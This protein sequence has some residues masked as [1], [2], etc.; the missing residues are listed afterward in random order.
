MRAFCLP[1]LLIKCSSVKILAIETSCDET[2]A[3][4]IENGRKILS[5]VVA[6][7][8]EI[9]KKYGGIVPEVASRKH[10]ESIA[11]VV[12]QALDDAKTSLKKIDAVAA[13]Y[14]PG[15][16]G[17]LIVGLN[18]AK[19]IAY[20]A[21]KPFIPV[22][23]IEGHI[24]ANFIKEMGD[25]RSEIRKNKSHLR[26][27]ISSLSFPFICLVVS[28]GHTQLVLVKSHGK[29]QTLG[30]TRDDAAGEAFDKVA[31]FLGI[32]YPGGPLID[33]MAKQGDPEAIDFPRA[34]MNDGYDF[35][36]SG[37]KTAVV[38]YV[39]HHEKAQTLNSKFITDIVASFQEAVVDILVEKTIRAAKKRKVKWI[40]LAG[41]VSAN[42]RLRSKLSARAG[43]EGL[44]ISIPPMYLCTD[45]AAMIGSAAYYLKKNAK[46]RNLDIEAVSTL[47]I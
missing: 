18:Y 38:N 31:R 44:K 22:N 46:K 45:N 35:S 19:A 34:M 20:A 25:K 36:F 6:S 11:A 16:V 39:R 8:V 28:G 33:K 23:H 5:N 37:I 47:R 41:G 14:G 32:G 1:E 27:P 43:K 15:L 21:G 29:Y 12:K 3:A 24:Y 30:R 9:H 10:I 7:Q 26:S 17:S 40:A 4:V 2:S 42:S 13:T